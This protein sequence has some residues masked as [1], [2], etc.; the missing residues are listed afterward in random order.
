MHP[1]P[2]F[3]ELHIRVF[4]SALKCNREER[5]DDTVN[6]AVNITLWL[7]VVNNLCFISVAGVPCRLIAALIVAEFWV[8][9]Y[10][11]VSTCT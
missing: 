1:P 11:E 6:I 7:C 5:D 2:C 3:F 9:Y 10:Y 4:L 8:I